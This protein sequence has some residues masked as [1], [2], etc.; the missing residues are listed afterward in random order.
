VGGQRAERGQ[1]RPGAVVNP[2]KF[3]FSTYLLNPRHLHPFD[4]FG[5]IN[6]PKGKF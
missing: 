1:H 6:V 3:F 5:Q 2:L 4:P